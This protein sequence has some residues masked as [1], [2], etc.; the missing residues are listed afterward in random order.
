MADKKKK[1]KVK[2]AKVKLK[3]RGWTIDE[4]RGMEERKRRE[5]RIRESLRNHREW[6]KAKKKKAKKKKSKK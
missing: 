6:L 5:K 2:P 4:Y 1:K 3:E